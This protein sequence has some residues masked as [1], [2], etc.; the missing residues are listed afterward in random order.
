MAVTPSWRDRHRTGTRIGSVGEAQTTRRCSRIVPVAWLIVSEVAATL[1]VSQDHVRR[2]IRRGELPATNVATSGRPL[3]RVSEENIEQYMSER[4]TAPQ[5]P[6][7]RRRRRRRDS[8]DFS[9]R[10]R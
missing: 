10:R 7:G 9:A 6:V 4:Q 8:A 3:Y 5:P 1:R 2:L